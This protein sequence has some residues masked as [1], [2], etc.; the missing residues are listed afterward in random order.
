MSEMRVTLAT[1]RLTL[2][3][4]TEADVPA[5]VVALDDYNV[6]G[7]LTVVPFPYTEADA[8]A[9]IGGLQTAS[10][11]DGYGIFDRTGLVGGIGIAETLGYWIAWDAW[12]RG[13]ATEAAEALVGHYFAETD[14]ESLG[15]GHFEGN[16]PSAHVLEK[17]G[18]THT[19]AVER[20]KSRAQ[21]IDMSL[22][23]MML[24]R[25][26]WETRSGG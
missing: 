16:I 21:G 10:R 15:S 22:E 11:F 4:L 5:L 26:S 2:R 3:P 19:G 8:R 17:L 9:F 14:A 23:K 7:W 13:Y 20:V 6:S 18:F 25:A 12:G 24:T 1:E